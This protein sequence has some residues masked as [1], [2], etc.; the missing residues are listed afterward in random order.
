MIQRQG[1][2]LPPLTVLYHVLDVLESVHKNKYDLRNDTDFTLYLSSPS[3][4]VA[5]HC[6]S[7]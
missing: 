3:P 2:L 5:M 7:E 4:T 1:R 6:S